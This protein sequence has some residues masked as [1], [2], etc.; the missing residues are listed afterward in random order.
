MIK[1]CAFLSL[2]LV[3]CR[4]GSEFKIAAD[5][6][7]ET[8]VAIPGKSNHAP[9]AAYDIDKFEYE[10]STDTYTCPQGHQMASNGKW[11]QTRNY[12]FKQYK[13]TA[14][15]D[16]PVK[17][18]CTTAKKSGRVLQR[19]EHQSHVEANAIRVANNE[20]LYKRRQAIVEHPFGTIKRQWG[21][22][23]VMTKKTIKRASADVGLIFIAYNLTRIWNILKEKLGKKAALSSLLKIGLAWLKT[24]IHKRLKLSGY[25]ILKFPSL[26]KNS[27]RIA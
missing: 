6:D 4:P 24:S 13:T 21:F 18:L 8:L 9:D 22:D 15:K 17:E 14:C 3:G 2:S 11:Y 27:L 26:R 5:L 10:E 7:I 23:H 16:C 20:E 19:S 25:D 1:A 12:E